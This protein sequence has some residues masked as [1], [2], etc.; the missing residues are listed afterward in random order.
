MQLCEDVRS[1]EKFHNSFS[2]SLVLSFEIIA[3]LGSDQIDY[4]TGC[5]KTMQLQEARL[6]TDLDY[7]F[8]I[9]YCLI[10]RFD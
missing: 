7:T 2:L 1:S 4:G 5:S 3:P 8:V 6:Q 10:R 9:I